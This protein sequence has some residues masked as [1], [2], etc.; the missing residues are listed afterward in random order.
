MKKEY[1]KPELISIVLSSE[2]AVTATTSFTSY[3]MG[4]TPSP[5]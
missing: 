2:E 3:E 1:V 4:V 5:F